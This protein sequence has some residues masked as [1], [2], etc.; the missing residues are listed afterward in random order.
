M[1]TPV[2]V[3]TR[4]TP[5]L[6]QASRMRQ[7]QDRMVELDQQISTGEKFTD[8]SQ[9]P[10][11]ATRAAVLVR[12]QGQLDADRTA[13]DRA[14]A[15]LAT[16]ETA[17]DG[18]GTLVLRARDLALSAANGTISADNRIVIAQELTMLKQ[19]LVDAANTTDDGGRYAFGGAQNATQPY[20][21][22]ADGT[23]TWQGFGAG[24]GAEAAGVSNAAPPSGPQ[25]FGDDATGL[26]AQI[27]KLVAAMAEPDDALR[28]AAIGDSITALQGA[29]DRLSLAQSKIG[30]SRARF[31]SERQRITTAQVEVKSQLADV[32]GVD[33]TAAL[34][35]WQALQL[36]MSAAQ[37][38]FS[39][40]FDGTLFDRLG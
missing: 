15:R 29:H 39:K 4:A 21:L 36:S 6:V 38:S 40:L 14:D 11:G 20:A 1:S 12:T 34:T 35:E 25:I 32:K 16:A 9:D 7:I 17:I 22:A 30:V 18:A 31:D 10:A 37:G 19:Q 23:V 2:Y 13:L 33:L 8:A 3:N 24:A 28:N 27:D 5:I 26:F